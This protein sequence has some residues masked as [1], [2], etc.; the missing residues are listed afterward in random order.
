M[1]SDNFEFCSL[2][3]SRYRE[4]A[5]THGLDVPDGQQAAW[6]GI[7]IC[8]PTDAEAEARAEDMR[9]LWQNW[10]IPFGQPFPM[11][12]IGSPDTITRKIEEA[13]ARFTID[14]TFLIFPQGIL[15]PEQNRASLELF[16]TRVMPRFQ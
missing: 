15:P 1:L 14:D 8:A 6:G 11:P 5:A 7:M 4:E 13:A 16:A 3:W 12:L 9:W 2:L 10:S